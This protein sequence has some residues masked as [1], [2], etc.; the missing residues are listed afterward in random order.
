MTLNGT[1]WVGPS[2]RYIEELERI[3]KD[4]QQKVAVLQAQANSRSK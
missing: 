1:E 2:G 3:V 4:L